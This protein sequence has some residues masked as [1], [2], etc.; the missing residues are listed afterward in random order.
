[1]FGIFNK[2][3]NNVDW[4]VVL[5]QFLLFLIALFL[6]A[7]SFVS[8]FLFIFNYLIF[9]IFET[10]FLICYILPMFCAGF[11]FYLYCL[12]NEKESKKE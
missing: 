7:F 3:W 11:N 2:Y 1:M 4:K 9:G 6:F 10:K 8:G 5:I 12:S